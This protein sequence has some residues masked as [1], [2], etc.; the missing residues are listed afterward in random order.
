M[1]GVGIFV[2]SYIGAARLQGHASFGA[3]SGGCEIVPGWACAVH[4]DF[5]LKVGL[6]C[7]CCYLE[8]GE[9]IAADTTN[10]QTLLRMGEFFRCYNRPFLLAG[11]FNVTPEVLQASG[12]VDSVLGSIQR[13]KPGTCRSAAGNWSCID[14]YV[15]SRDLAQAATNTQLVDGEPP[16]P[17]VPVQLT[18]CKKPSA[19]QGTCFEEGQTVVPV[20]APHR[21]PT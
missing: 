3:G 10:W 2:R 20:G 21:L 13:S 1:A 17:H 7:G 9:G 12:W 8:A 6:I 16:I 4:V 11:D 18:L 15:I 5:A 14:Y 19:T